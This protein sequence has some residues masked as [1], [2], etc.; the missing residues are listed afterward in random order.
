MRP[1]YVE[2]VNG[3]FSV[4]VSAIVRVTLR[5]G[6]FQEDV[7]FGTGENRSRGAAIESAKKEAISDARK[8]AL[9]LFGNALGN[10]IYDREYLETLDVPQRKQA[11]APIRYDDMHRSTQSEFQ[12]PTLMTP[13]ILP[14]KQA[15]TTLPIVSKAIGVHPERQPQPQPQP[16]TATPSTMQQPQPAQVARQVPQSAS[17]VRQVPQPAPVLVRQQPQTA[18]VSVRQPQPQPQPAPLVI[19]QQPQPTTMS[20]PIRQRPQPSTVV[21][22]SIR[23][24]PQAAVVVRPN[25]SPTPVKPVVVQQQSPIRPIP[26]AQQTSLNPRPVVVQSPPRAQPKV[27]MV[28]NQNHSS[29]RVSS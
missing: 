2:E 27:V 3:R 5:N 7:G 1:D 12:S 9:R 26:V 18:P 10:S 20:S 22:P 13:G 14:K 29:N 17:V 21:T 19:R 15:R 23:Q 28:V 16:T 25:G 11:I 6:A 8:R 4:G 24:Q